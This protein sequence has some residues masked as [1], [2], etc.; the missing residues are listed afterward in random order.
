MADA[1]RN[2][3]TNPTLARGLQPARFFGA[4][5]VKLEDPRIGA[6]A[7]AALEYRAAVAVLRKRISRHVGQAHLP[8]IST[9]ISSDI[10]EGADSFLLTAL[11]R[12]A[13]GR[14]MQ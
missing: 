14:R 5:P 4:L 7:G 2:A 6:G 1:G 9:R 13:A 8:A 12:F 10:R 3:Q 11:Y